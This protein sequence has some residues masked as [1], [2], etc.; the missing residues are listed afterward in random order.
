V[1]G[2]CEGGNKAS[3]ILEWLGN[4]CLRRRTHVNDIIQL[5]NW[6]VRQSVG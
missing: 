4:F 5:V 3:E 2:Y 1:V 6:L